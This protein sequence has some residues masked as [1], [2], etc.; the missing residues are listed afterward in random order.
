MK[1]YENYKKK[2][3]EKLSELSKY[4]LSPL[5]EIIKLLKVLKYTDYI[6]QLENIEKHEVLYFFNIGWGMKE[7]EFPFLETVEESF[8]RPLLKLSHTDYYDFKE[9]YKLVKTAY[10]FNNKEW[11]NE[12]NIN[13]II[14]TL[15]QKLVYYVEDYE[16]ERVTP[17]Y[18]LEYLK[19]LQDVRWG[20]EISK[21]VQ[22][23]IADAVNMLQL[24][25]SSDYKFPIA[26]NTSA[27]FLMICNVVKN[28]RKTIIFN[29]VITAYLTV[30]K[31]IIKNSDEV[32]ND[33]ET[34]K[35]IKVEKKKL[36]VKNTLYEIFGII[37]IFLLV[38]IIAEVLTRLSII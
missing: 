2:F 29:D 24:T 37:G 6:E 26:I 25:K 21:E 15:L 3:E 4:K 20:N 27:T 11:E 36:V 10:I 31:I 35:L 38:I 18:S 9:L 33:F 14:I 30:L 1:S 22:Q 8:K 12:E 34:G 5:N 23:K 16:N 32:I 19:Q 28:K 7:A 17:E 13:E